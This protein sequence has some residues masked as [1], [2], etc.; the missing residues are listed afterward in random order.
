MCVYRDF[1]YFLISFREKSNLRRGQSESK[2][3]EKSTPHPLPEI[4]PDD[5]LALRRSLIYEDT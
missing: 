2:R 4:N 1:I 5:D 3:G